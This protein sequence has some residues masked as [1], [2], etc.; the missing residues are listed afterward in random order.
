M[1][2]VD[3]NWI[4]NKS[5]YV[6]K[7]N[8]NSFDLNK[9]ESWLPVVRKVFIDISSLLRTLKLS[10]GDEVWFS[11]DNGR[12]S[13][14]QQLLSTY[15][16][17]RDD[18]DELFRP[19]VLEIESLLRL[20]GENTM[21]IKNV[22]SDDLIY[23]LSDIRKS[24]NTLTIIVSGDQDLQQLVNQNTIIVKPFNGILNIFTSNGF[25]P[26]IFSNEQQVEQVDPKLILFK[27]ILLGDVSDDIPRII[28][29][30]IG[31]KTLEK[32]YIKNNSLDLFEIIQLFLE[33][34]RYIIDEYLFERQNLLIN[35]QFSKRV[36]NDSNI[37]IF[38]S[39][40]EKIKKVVNTSPRLEDFLEGTKYLSQYV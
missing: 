38:E 21:L 2:I 18:K 39:F 36:L 8:S 15:K 6:F 25:V 13:Y 12:S 30:G 11:F 33:E 14:R 26:P 23:L 1:I 31:P 16:E 19:L 37:R 24:L 28:R 5:Y 7:S 35:L 3:T 22:E 4:I 20:K 17:S 9:S 34:N 40:F 27:K 10:K 29:K 32:F